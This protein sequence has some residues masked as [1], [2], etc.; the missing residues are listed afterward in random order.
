[1][2]SWESSAGL[3]SA[4]Y[5]A[6]RLVPIAA[7]VALTTRLRTEVSEALAAD[8]VAP[9]AQLIEAVLASGDHALM[10]R[11][12]GNRHL[13]EDTAVRMAGYG[14]PDVGLALLSRRS[15]TRV[16]EA[17]W[18]AADPASADWHTRLVVPLLKHNGTRLLRSMLRS[19]FP[20]AVRHAISRL[21]PY[22]PP[23]VV[24]ER[25]VGIC[26]T[27]T[28]LADTHTEL[29][30]FAELF[31]DEGMHHPDLAVVFGDAARAEDP[32]AVLAAARTRLDGR[33]RPRA[34]HD[35]W[36]VGLRLDDR[37]DAPAGGVDWAAILREDDRLPYDTDARIE[38][39]RHDGC[40]ERLVFAT[41]R[42][43]VASTFGTRTHFEQRVGP[44]PFA[45]LLAPETPDNDHQL[46][47]LLAWGIEN[48][49]F[50]FDE[51]LRAVTPAG[52]VVAALGNL[53]PRR[54]DSAVGDPSDHADV[55]DDDDDRAFV[56]SYRGP[57]PDALAP[58]VA[59]LIEPLG[60]DPEAWISLHKLLPRFRGTCHELVSAAVAHAAGER[61]K[62][63]PVTWTRGLAARF[64]AEA[65]EGA[66][67]HLY[68]LLAA[69]PDHVQCAV[70]PALDLRAIQHLSV[71]HPLSAAVRAHVY[72]VR[73]V[74]AA[75]ACASRWDMPADVVEGLLDLDDPEVNA[76]LYDFGGIARH[77][78]IRIC[79]GRPRAGGHR[80][81]PISPALGDLLARTSPSTRR[82]WL[83]AAIDS[84][85]PVLVRVMLGRMRLH[86]EVGRL[87]VAVA[88]WE[89]HGPDA[90]SA[91]L[92]ETHFPGRRPA[93]KHPFPATTHHLLRTA[94][95]APEAG[96]ASIR[97]TLAA[98][99][100]PD[101][102]AEHLLRGG[103]IQERLEHFED[104][105]D[106][107]V[108]WARLI[109]ADEK[110]PLSKES[111][112]ALAAHPDC[113]PHLLTAYLVRFG[114]ADGARDLDRWPAD[115]AAGHLLPADLLTANAPASHVL[116]F[117]GDTLSA[118]T[119]EFARLVDEA[120][121][122]T[123]DPGHWAVLLRLVPEFTGT[124]PELL[125]TA[126][127]VLR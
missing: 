10:A 103:R 119:E 19:P 76:N 112:A 5:A 116:A 21:A 91:L 108:P 83:L 100:T 57:V 78:R 54:A 50:P 22:L 17:V 18:A 56:R 42:A 120:G 15:D 23:W 3:R 118:F 69:A 45:A 38:L 74:E 121:L 90:V 125:A 30:G 124:L 93:A 43:G 87:R 98:A 122:D 60:D 67:K 51:V 4:L 127:A 117:L 66:R 55:D 94:L 28:R 61:A 31:H 88:L 8:H 62:G 82:H 68:T 37:A 80:R 13:D 53:C 73:G 77:E 81:I 110:Q 20:D 48:D 111:L 64:P 7:G 63:T 123:A 58:S 33:D 47:Y 1:M 126:A 92:A 2:M 34:D 75:V 114:I 97:E 86:T 26:A 41:V 71:F 84:G 46:A 11:L 16:H 36:L 59:R 72:A 106:V 104:E 35:A 115:L 95:A 109:V 89:R 40:P 39:T 32:T 79:A 85:D 52:A 70:I 25:V 12:A 65:P 14:D 105:Y 102:A 9:P 99:R 29:R 6:S 107:A 96:S 113:P 101:A 49:R 44:V 24:V 27:H